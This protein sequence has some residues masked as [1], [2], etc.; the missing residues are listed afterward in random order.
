TPLCMSSSSS[1]TFD[2]PVMDPLFYRR[3]HLAVA[4]F[5]QKFSKLSSLPNNVLKTVE[6]ANSTSPAR[7]PLGGI[8]RNVLNS[9]FPASTKG[10]GGLDRSIGCLASTRHDL[11][12]SVG[13]T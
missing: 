13:H 4:I 8:Q 6:S 9:R 5:F 3:P 2:A 7:S 11:G 1:M 10:C 12:S